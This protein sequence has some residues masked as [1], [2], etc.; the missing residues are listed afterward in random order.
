[1]RMWCIEMTDITPKEFGHKRR[2]KVQIA[3][4][5]DIDLFAK[6]SAA[7]VKND[8]SLNSVINDLVRKALK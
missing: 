6:I 7:S 4:R 2:E 1:M 8:V 5:F 3:I